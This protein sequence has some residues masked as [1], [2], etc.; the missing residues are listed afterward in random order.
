[1]TILGKIRIALAASLFL[2]LAALGGDRLLATGGAHQV[3]GAGGGGIVPWALIAGYGTNAQV[4][5]S[6]FYTRVQ[7]D[8]FDLDSYGAAVG[9]FNRVELS[10]AKQQFDASAVVPG[11]D[12]KT[13]TFGAKVRLLNDAV[14]DQDC[15][16]PQWSVG[17][18]HKRNTT[19]TIPTA[20]GAVRGSDTDFYVSAT[21]IWLAGLAGR[22]VVATANLRWTRANQLGLLGFGGDKKSSRSLQPEISAAVLLTDN[23]GLGA[24]YRWKP[25]NL[26]AFKEDDFADVFLAWFPHRHVAITA[27]WAKLGSIAGKPRQDG[28]YLSLQLTY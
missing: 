18:M 5:G 20:I 1:M 4:G 24:E 26:S 13:E 6:A 12:L 19:M 17:F 23:L 28:P 25:D 9:L 27:A 22:N 10:F 7:S 14:Y 11:L 8:D 16:W 15:P 2:P 21:K 3:E